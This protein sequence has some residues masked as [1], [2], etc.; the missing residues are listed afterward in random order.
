MCVK[1]TVRELIQ[2]K[3]KN[4]QH[5]YIVDFVCWKR[6]GLWKP[7]NVILAQHKWKTIHKRNLIKRKRM[8][9]VCLRVRHAHLSF[10][11][12]HRNFFELKK[13]NYNENI[14][15]YVCMCILDTRVIV[16]R[17]FEFC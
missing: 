12:K 7:F 5:L 14:Y 8:Y 15:I 4:Q 11:V 17:F 13:R 2:K 1:Q 9:L 6:A 16:T 3:K 10:K